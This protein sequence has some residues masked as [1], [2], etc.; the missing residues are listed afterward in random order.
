[1]CG[2]ID[3]QIFEERRGIGS[4]PRVWGNLGLAG[5]RLDIPRFTP[6]C[7]G[8]SPTPSSTP[9]ALSVHPHVCGEILEEDVA[10]AARDG[11]PPRVWG[12]LKDVGIVFEGQRFTPTCVGK[13]WCTLAPQS[14][15]PVHPHV[16]GE[17]EAIPQQTTRVS[18]SPPRVWGNLDLGNNVIEHRRFTPTCVGKSAR[19][20]WQAAMTTVHP[21]VCGEIYQRQQALRLHRGSPPRVWGNLGTIK[22]DLHP[23]RFT[24]T[25]VGKSSNPETCFSRFAVHPHVCGEIVAIAESQQADDGSPPRVWGNLGAILRTDAPLRFT[26]TCVGK[27]GSRK[28]AARAR[29]VHPHVC[30]EIHAILRAGVAGIGSPPRVWGNPFQPT[31]RH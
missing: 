31:N 24:P 23:I 16:C 20:L 9:V 26:P 3:A 11:S 8:K 6:T 4:P 30:G 19:I 13:S 21:H 2:E 28:S 15:L 18:G 25:C 27:S 7:V 12:N 5:D 1:M 22:F 29:P 14:C 10:N 17:I